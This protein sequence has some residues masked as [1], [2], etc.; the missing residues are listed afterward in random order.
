MMQWSSE[1]QKNTHKIYTD[2][3]SVTEIINIVFY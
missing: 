1:Y 3:F 2:D